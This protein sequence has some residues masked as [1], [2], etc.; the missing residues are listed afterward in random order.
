MATVYDLKN[1]NL[2][3]ELLGDPV[4]TGNLLFS[5]KT[6]IM[7]AVK[8]SNLVKAEK[9]LP[10]TQVMESISTGNADQRKQAIDKFMGEWNL[11]LSIIYE[12]P[13]PVASPPPPKFTP[14]VKSAGTNKRTDDEGF[15]HPSK[16]SKIE[17][18]IAI[19]SHP[20]IKL[21]NAFEQLSDDANDVTEME[22]APSTAPN[23]EN[24]KIIKPPPIFMK[25]SNNFV[26]LIDSLQ[27]QLNSVLKKRVSGDLL[28]IHPSDPIQYN[29]IL[30]F[31]N[32]NKIEFF[33]SQPKNE[34]PKKV[35]L[36]GIPKT[37]STLDVKNALTQLNFEIHR[38]SQLRNYKTKEPYP[39]YLVDI[40][41]T[42]NYL[43]IFKLDNFFGYI[44]KSVPYK[45]RGPKQCYNCQRY[46]HSSDN[47]HFEPRCNK[48]AGNH[49]FSSCTLP[50][51]NNRDHIK[52]INCR[53]N[54]VANW[55]GCPKNPLNLKKLNTIQKSE[56][57]SK[58]SNNSVR[59]GNSFADVT[60]PSPSFSQ[61]EISSASESRN[62]KF[63]P[64]E[65]PPLP[66]LDNKTNSSTP[67]IPNSHNLDLV[68]EKLKEIET[69]LQNIIKL[70]NNPAIPLNFLKSL[71]NIED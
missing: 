65:F 44:I 4:F 28:Q 69:R 22:S 12:T 36:K 31:L 46:S 18:N 20:I 1:L 37:F 53:D 49:H 51:D 21:N 64:E 11:L 30:N 10:F 5:L 43:D 25:M 58:K 35:L 27:N 29:A 60:R 63:Q 41:P 61:S 17:N 8:D 71:L 62:T 19:N 16:V 38:V 3:R 47:C 13:T 66:N 34:R 52:C 32:L 33:S 45:S 23:A 14:A 6:E 26:S 50:K 9:I 56:N 68:I 7:N 59:K 2:N 24:T 48:C 70:A 67:N 15:T 57:A 42:G 55:K 40:M 39:C 54:H